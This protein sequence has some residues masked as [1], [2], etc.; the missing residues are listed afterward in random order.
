MAMLADRLE[1]MLVSISEEFKFSRKPREGHNT[2]ISAGN[3]E[4][5]IEPLPPGG[6]AEAAREKG[7]Q[8]NEALLN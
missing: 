2:E 1:K 3:R 8:R 7:Q 5:G 4:K 6:A